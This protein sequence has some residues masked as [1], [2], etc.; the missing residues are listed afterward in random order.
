MNKIKCGL[1]DGSGK[2]TIYD[3]LPCIL[4]H[5]DGDLDLDPACTELCKICDGSG[6]APANRQ[7]PCSHCGGRRYVVP[8]GYKPAPNPLPPEDLPMVFFV[9]AGK[10]RTAQLRI[11]EIFGKLSGEVRICDPY[12]GVKSLYRLDSLKH[13]KPIKFLT[14]KADPSETQTLPS[15]LQVWKQ[16]HGDIEFRRNAGRTLHDRFVLCDDELVLIGHGL[17]DV[18]G[19]DSFIIRIGRDFADDMMDTLR[20]SFDEKWQKATLIV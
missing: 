20:K 10:P 15:A 8:R 19:K 16:E 6:K 2:S 9:E 13:C 11:E 4:C 1:C 3:V 18:G 14:S 7:M 5:G 17:K 12:Y